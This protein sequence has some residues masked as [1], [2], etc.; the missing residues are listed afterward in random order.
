MKTIHKIIRFLCCLLPWEPD[1]RNPF[2]FNQLYQPCG[3]FAVS[4]G[5]GLRIRGHPTGSLSAQELI[6]ISPPLAQEGTLLRRLEHKS[7]IS[8]SLESKTRLILLSVG[9]VTG[10]V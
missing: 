2:K 10:L 4:S 6:M 8:N 5:I 3:L 1:L 7:F 9:R